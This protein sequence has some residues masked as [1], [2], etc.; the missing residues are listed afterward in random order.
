MKTF[1]AIVLLC[2]AAKACATTLLPAPE[3]APLPEV[4]PAQRVPFPDW[5]PASVRGGAPGGTTNILGMSAE[6]VFP[7][8]ADRPGIVAVAFS[9][10]LDR[11]IA[12]EG[13]E[14]PASE[15]GGAIFCRAVEAG[16]GYRFLEG[17][18]KDDDF[19]PNAVYFAA[20]RVRRYEIR[21]PA[22]LL[23]DAAGS[24]GIALAYATR[25]ERGQVVH[26]AECA[27]LPVS[28]VSPEP[29][30]A[31]TNEWRT[32]VAY[33]ATNGIHYGSAGMQD[34]IR[35][36]PEFGPYFP[37]VVLDESLPEAFRL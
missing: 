10:R 6:W 37:G 15:E 17:F 13:L 28:A 24:Q 31:G 36:Y 33:W 3:P 25:Q 16:G 30:V 26:W 35:D 23:A 19:G 21:L 5:L 4:D 32:L 7:P 9:N 22:E 20:G 12:V 1:V 29:G 27:P 11:K 34:V 2:A 8:P 18:P 14:N